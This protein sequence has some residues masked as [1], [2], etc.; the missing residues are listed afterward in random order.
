MK[1]F[2]ISKQV[3]IATCIIILAA[4]AIATGSVIAKYAKTVGEDKSEVTAKM[5]YFESDYL[6]VN[7]KTENPYKLNSGVKS[8]SFELR[9]FEDD[10][11]ISQVTCNYTVTI[12]T[13]DADFAIE[14]TANGEDVGAITDKT[15]FQLTANANQK[16]IHKI[17]LKNLKPGTQ[18]DITVTSNGGYVKTMYASFLVAEAAGGFYMNRTDYGAYVELTV[19]TEGGFAK[20]DVTISVPDGLIPDVTDSILKDIVNYQ[21]GI[22]KEFDFTDTT[23]FNNVETENPSRAYRFFK[24]ANYNSQNSFTVTMEGISALAQEKNLP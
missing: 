7:K 21:D 3:L 4:L 6:T 10:S 23:T 20:G 11:N 2:Q 19:W 22:Y 18:Y 8:V 24:A 13:T 15:N 1:K 9:N 14:A 5:F 17:T 12:S 16:N